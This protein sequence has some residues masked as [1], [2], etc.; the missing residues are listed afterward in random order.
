MNIKPKQVFSTYRWEGNT[1]LDNVKYC[2]HCGMKF[3]QKMRRGRERLICPKCGFTHYRNPYPGVVVLIIENG[4]VL[5]GKRA[6]GC[7][8]EGKWCLPG[9][10]IEYE[11]N[12]L[13]AAK[14]EVKEET[15][16]DIEVLSIISVVTNYFTPDLHT[17]VIVLLARITGGNLCPGDDIDELKWFPLSKPFPEMAFEA[18]EHIITR[19]WNTELEGAPIDPDLAFSIENSSP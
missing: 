7:F 3:V 2:S 8:L 15:A 13:S 10:F 19:F 1:G 18:D 16:L 4:S 6:K 17:L 12:F 11:E 9:G 5:L 14:R